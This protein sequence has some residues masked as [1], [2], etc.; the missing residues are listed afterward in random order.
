MAIEL[1]AAATSI[2]RPGKRESSSTNKGQNPNSRDAR[3]P[4]KPHE[5]QALGS[6]TARGS[7]R[8]FR[9]TFWAP[10]NFSLALAQGAHNAP[11]LWGDKTVREQHE[12]TGILS[13]IS[14]GCKVCRCRSSST[15]A[16]LFEVYR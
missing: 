13:G 14:A 12:I 10:M 9:A 7:A 5:M 6:A 2:A 4:R 8:V 16:G 1:D 3:E 11:K 15:V